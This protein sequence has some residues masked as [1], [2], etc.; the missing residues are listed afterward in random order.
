MLRVV[1]LEEFVE[2]INLIM[3]RDRCS[4]IEAVC[5][6]AEEHEVDFDALVPHINASFKESIRVEAENKNMMKK[7]ESQLPI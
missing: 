2:H 7:N 4:L 3:T 1:T 6:Y 5:S